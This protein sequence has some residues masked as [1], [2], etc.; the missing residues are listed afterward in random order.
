[1]AKDYFVARGLR[2]NRKWE[3]LDVNKLKTKD[4]I[5]IL[6]KREYAMIQ[7]IDEDV[8]GQSLSKNKIV[9]LI[10][11]DDF[12]FSNKGNIKC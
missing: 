10:S 7:E 8:I 2:R 5:E 12:K 11:V 1:M 9:D 3:E 6:T 4:A